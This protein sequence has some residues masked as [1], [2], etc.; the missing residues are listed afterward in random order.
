MKNGGDFRIKVL[1]FLFVGGF[2]TLVDWLLYFVLS[3]LLDVPESAAKTISI[4]ASCVISFFLNKNITFSDKNKITSKTVA[5]FTVGQVL[6][7]AINT[8]VNSMSLHLTDNKILSLFA[9]TGVAMVFNFCFQN[10]IVFNR[11]AK[12]KDV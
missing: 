3:E 10:F 8:A 1:R 2:C 4:T 12:E 5:L 11:S 7:I 9:A 6:N